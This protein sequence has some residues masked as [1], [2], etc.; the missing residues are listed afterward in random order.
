MKVDIPMAQQAIDSFCLDQNPNTVLRVTCKGVFNRTYSLQLVDK[1]KE[2]SL[3]QKFLSL[4]GAST[5][6]LKN[7]ASII[8]EVDKSSH[9]GVSKTYAGKIYEKINQ[10]LGAGNKTQKQQAL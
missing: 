5:F 3:L 6:N 7:V 1:T 8:R 10:K 9:D 2:M 4:F